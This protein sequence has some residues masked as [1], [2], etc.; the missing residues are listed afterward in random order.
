MRKIVTLYS[1][2][3]KSQRPRTIYI[4]C[5]G[6]GFKRPMYW[7]DIEIS[8]GS[9]KRLDTD[10]KQRTQVDVVCDILALSEMI[11]SK[12]YLHNLDVTISRKWDTYARHVLNK[13][14]F[15]KDIYDQLKGYIRSAL[16]QSA[17]ERLYKSLPY[18]LYLRLGNA[19]SVESGWRFT[20]WVLEKLSRYI[21]SWERKIEESSLR[22][23]D[24]YFNNILG[25]AKRILEENQEAYANFIRET[26]ESFVSTQTWLLLKLLTLGHQTQRVVDYFDEEKIH[27]LALE[28]YDHLEDGVRRSIRLAWIGNKGSLAATA[29]VLRASIDREKVRDLTEKCIQKYS[30]GILQPFVKDTVRTLF[31]ESFGAE[32]KERIPYWI[33]LA[34]GREVTRSLKQIGNLLPDA[35]EQDIYSDEFIFGSTPIDEAIDRASIRLLDKRYRRREKA[36][37]VISDGEFET[38]SPL[39]SAFLLKQA[40]VT[41]VSCYITNR[42]I[43]T[44]LVSRRSKRWPDGAKRLFKMA[45]TVDEQNQW[46]KAIERNGFRVPE[47]VKL[48][49]QINQSDLLGDILQSILVE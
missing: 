42:N 20:G 10:L 37:I 3:G 49:Y 39:T 15:D 33:G 9:E 17:Y 4:F 2:R 36:L 47:G 18:R 34:S 22:S 30:W 14:T 43:M 35:L 11:P 1:S 27:E 38:D 16:R 8:Y 6:M 45:S 44:K 26:L 21:E 5:L 13:I 31:V 40:G 28:I 29:K 19:F 25:E 41:I 12:K 48:F 24:R 7:S 32:A 23:S 46:V